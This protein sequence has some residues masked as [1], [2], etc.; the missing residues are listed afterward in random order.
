MELIPS[1]DV[2]AFMQNLGR[3]FTDAEKATIIYNL[4][5]DRTKRFDELRKLME[6]TNDL[7]LKKEI[8][9]RFDY[10]NKMFDSFATA[11]QDCVYVL[12]YCDYE[13]EDGRMI[14]EEYFS[15]L[16][17]ARKWGLSLEQDYQVDKVRIQT[18]AECDPDED[19]Y[20]RI[21]SA[22]Y[23]E[24]GILTYIQSDEVDEKENPRYN[25]DECQRF[26][27]AYVTIPHPFKHG[28]VV[29]NVITGGIGIVYSWNSKWDW[30][31]FEAYLHECGLSGDYPDIGM[32]VEMLHENGDF[33]HTHPSPL[34]LEYANLTKADR[35][36]DVMDAASELFKG[37]GSIEYLQMMIEE[38]LKADDRKRI[39]VDSI[40]R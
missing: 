18:I 10:E 6:A 35:E 15:N 3:E 21:G 34:E 2:R 25:D 38:Y 17:A 39:V 36:Y 4:R 20:E 12:C 37:H 24:N 7:T 40:K 19:L 32:N 31:K 8:Q 27:L 13:S 1:K 26:E 9:E 5:E 14:T 28:D 30:D 16:E 22:N 23:D 29:R 11:R 33:C